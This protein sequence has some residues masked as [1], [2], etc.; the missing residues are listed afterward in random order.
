M[1]RPRRHQ[2]HQLLKVRKEPY[3]K[4]NRV[5][6]REKNHFLDKSF[7]QLAETYSTKN[8]SQSVVSIFIFHNLSKTF[9][10][11]Q[12]TRLP[13]KCHMF[14]FFFRIPFFLRQHHT[15][16]ASIKDISVTS[17]C[18]YEGTDKVSFLRYKY[19]DSQRLV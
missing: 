17:I 1:E 13:C 7:T 11:F 18:L 8:L 16:K 6:A 2:V 10:S 5:T 15:A 12:N 19:T 4:N 3:I 9:Q 14:E